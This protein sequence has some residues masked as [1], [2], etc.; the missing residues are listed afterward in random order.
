[1]MGRIACT[2]STKAI[3]MSCL[4]VA[5]A[6]VAL[7][8]ARLDRG[9][10]VQKIVLATME[11]AYSHGGVWPSDLDMSPAGRPDLD[12]ARPGTFASTTEAEE[13]ASETVVL[14][15]RL[16]RHPDGV[17]VGYADGHLEFAANADV[18]AGC[19]SQLPIVRAAIARYGSPFGAQPKPPIDPKSVAKQMAS[20]LRLRIVDPQGRP[21]IGA[22]VGVQ[23]FFRANS[24][25][26]ERVELYDQGDRHQPLISDN[27][28]IVNLPAQRVFDPAGNGSMFLDVDTAPL[29][30]LRETDGLAALGELHLADFQGNQTRE[31]IL[32][33]ACQITIGVSCIGLASMGKPL[34]HVECF[35]MKPG[36]ELI[37]AIFSS[38]ASTARSRQMVFSVPPGDYGICIDCGSADM[39]WR[40][41]H[42]S[43]GQQSLNLQIDL[44]LR[45]TWSHFG[46]PAPELTQIKGWK[47]GGPV[48][49]ADLR[50]K[51]VLLDFW[52]YWCGPCIG[53]MPYLMKLYNQFKDKGLM[54]IAV[55]DDSVA[56]I[57]EMDQKL[58]SARQK[59]WNG[60]DLPFLVALD[61][62]GETRIKY[63]AEL[64]R[65]ATTAAYGIDRFPTTL[66]IGPDGKVIQQVEV[67][68][69]KTA[70]QLAALLSQRPIT[71]APAAGFR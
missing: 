37:R 53:S 18:L 66:L 24:T 50:G 60:R 25:P 31:V 23:G 1:M 59:Y 27:S 49:L 71:A 19:H 47:N 55:H 68:D 35:A 13:L 44:R 7:A 4:V 29:W 3:F 28:G 2:F 51:Y 32:Q 69:P 52:G 20:M 45:L 38:S 43:P 57:A 16:S 39:A 58:T 63:S 41:V 10:A 26:D 56:S 61:G 12:Y 70:D 30:I 34:G 9:A 21:V 17:W 6:Q 15:E 40:Y 14:H 36:E 11:N 8:D 22:R 64:D 48:R 67:R 46:Q 62:G 33:P 42:I 5:A 54:I 65:G